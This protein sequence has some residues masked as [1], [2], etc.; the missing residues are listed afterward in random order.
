MFQLSL[1]PK[2]RFSTLHLSIVILSQNFQQDNLL[3][4][5]SYIASVTQTPLGKILNMK[6][7][8]LT[9]FLSPLDICSKLL[10]TPYS[11]Q[12]TVLP[13][14]TQDKHHI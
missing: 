14:A 7:R 11:A 5:Y 13:V 8:Y 4:I 2:I 1:P 10:K 3:H 12:A 9:P 6:A